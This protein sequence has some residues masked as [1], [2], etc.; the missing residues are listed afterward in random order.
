M[1]TVKQDFL[2]PD[3]DVLAEAFALDHAF[4][5]A[6]KGAVPWQKATEVIADGNCV[7]KIMHTL[8]RIALKREPM[9]NY[10]RKIGEMAHHYFG[11]GDPADDVIASIERGERGEMSYI[12]SFNVAL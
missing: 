8:K 6:V 11:Q 2:T 12:Q 4:N 7:E 3:Q 10:N 9:F 5:K 1:N